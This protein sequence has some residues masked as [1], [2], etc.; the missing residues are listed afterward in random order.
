MK[1]II[2]IL[3]ACLTGTILV[4][5]CVWLL[6]IAQAARQSAPSQFS[7]L[8][9]TEPK[10]ILVDDFKDGDMQNKLGGEGVCWAANGGTNSCN[11]QVV[12]NDG[13]L[14]MQYN[15]I[16]PG[17]YAVFSTDLISLN[18]TALDTVWTAVRGEAG[19]EP[20][21]VE[22]KDCGLEFPK[23]LISD[24]LA[25]GILSSEW[26][27]AA[28]PLA[29]FSE[30][31]DWSCIDRFSILAHNSIGSGQG[32]VYVDDIRLLP[33]QVLVDDFPDLSEENE[34]GGESGVWETGSG[35]IDYQYLQGEL[36]LD[37]DVNPD[38]E[39]NYW[40]KLRNTNLLSQKDAV[41][42]RVRGAQGSEEI[43]VEFIDCALGGQEHIPKIKVS[44]YLA[45]G[46][47]T[48][49]K[50][51]A[52]PLAAFADGMDWT[53]VKQFNILV[54][55]KDWFD[56]D[57]GTVFVDD[58]VLATTPRPIPLLV[59][60]FDDCNNWNALTWE[61]AG[62]TTGA[63]TL[64]FGPDAVHGY[65]DK[66]C[67]FR[68]TYD[69]PRNS[70]AWMIS[71]LKDLDVTDYTHLR[72][73]VKGAAGHEEL[74]VYLTDADASDRYVIVEADGDWQEVLIPL[75]YFGARVDLTRLAALKI[76]FEWRQ[77]S[78]EVYLDDISFTNLETYLPIVFKAFPQICS[79][80]MPSCSSPYNNY[81]PNNYRCSTTFE[82]SSGLP[83]QSYICAEDDSN[84]YYYIDVT[85]LDRITVRLTNI[86]SGVDY[87]LHLYY[88]DNWVAGSD[89][90]GN[91]AEEIDYMPSQT[92]RYYIRVYPYSGH[93]LSPYTLR[94]DYQ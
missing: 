12:G 8:G 16:P 59:D 72:F 26:S 6:N 73:F 93:S 11:V 55:Y 5:G 38:R 13:F 42:F 3:S 51:V 80:R 45:G 88:E 28:I 64:D 23:E 94:A 63:A 67:G 69:V 35:I 29:Q 49:W 14:D 33:A 85:T 4:I 84:D 1:G 74:H 78:G 81:E 2:R 54:S 65:G 21:Y 20:I 43:A 40:T 17:S 66:G 71:E 58:I 47:T 57:Q 82:L 86:P 18:M 83:I 39:A 52:V 53:C 50:E 44:D 87:D 76:A 70:S 77:M 61:W 15:V 27:G 36:K 68:I 24:Y 30:I 60:H 19:S 48:D 75:S 89:K 32:R 9:A 10:Y 22:F 62:Y 37:Y 56:S 41:L 25:Q 92:G 34:L 90:P 7:S 46:I 79:D 91:A 31:A